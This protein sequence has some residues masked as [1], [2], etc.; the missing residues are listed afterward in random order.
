[1]AIKIT[2]LDGASLSTCNS[3]G[4]KISSEDGVLGCGLAFHKVCIETLQKLAEQNVSPRSSSSTLEG[5]VKNEDQSESDT[6]QLVKM[7]VHHYRNN[8]GYT[9]LHLAVLDENLEHV[10]LLIRNDVAL[11]ASTRDCRWAIPLDLA[12][13]TGNPQIIDVLNEAKAPCTSLALKYTFQTR[14]DE[15][16]KAFYKILNNQSTNF[17]MYS[18]FHMSNSIDEELCKRRVTELI[19]EKIIDPESCYFRARARILLF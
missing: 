9:H 2:P 3:C 6:T 17:I 12:I 19:E 1:M 15:T 16:R 10:K 11:D 14:N 7:M 8:N 13:E 5:R 4:E 18:L